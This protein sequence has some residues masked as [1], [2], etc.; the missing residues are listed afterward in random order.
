MKQTPKSKKTP[1][2][3]SIARMAERGEDVSRFFSNRGRM[4][5]PIQRVNVDFTSAMLQETAGVRPGGD[6]TERESPGSDQGVC[7]PGARSALPGA[8]GASQLI[9]PPASKCWALTPFDMFVTFTCGVSTLDGGHREQH[10]RPRKDGSR[11]LNALR[12]HSVRPWK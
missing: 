7:P 3:E 2:A 1:S 6:R 4:I 5:Q 11:V 9:V 8:Q 10:G 12:F